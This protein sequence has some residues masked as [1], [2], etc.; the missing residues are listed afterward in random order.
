[1][2]R[3]FIPGANR[4]VRGQDVLS[5]TTARMGIQTSLGLVGGLNGFRYAFIV[6]GSGGLRGFWDLV[7]LVLG[8]NEENHGRFRG[9]DVESRFSFCRSVLQAVN[10]CGRHSLLHAL[11]PSYKL[12]FTISI[13]HHF[14]K[15]SSTVTLTF[16]YTPRFSNFYTFMHNNFTFF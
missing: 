12:L 3:V 11:F 8:S 6:T 13:L 16:L 5:L 4:C 10:L 2:I 1:M 9:S 14:Y 7:Y 15:W